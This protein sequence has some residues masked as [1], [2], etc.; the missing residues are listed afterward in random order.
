MCKL[1]INIYGALF[2]LS[3]AYIFRSLRIKFSCT[4]FEKRRFS[5]SICQ[6]FQHQD[7][8]RGDRWPIFCFPD[9]CVAAFFWSCVS[10]FNEQ[11]LPVCLYDYQK[12]RELKCPWWQNIHFTENCLQCFMAV[13]TTENEIFSFYYV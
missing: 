6:H 3:F 13:E 11:P 9:D 12:K 7:E 2:Y 4:C 5:L 1:S 8:N 10:T